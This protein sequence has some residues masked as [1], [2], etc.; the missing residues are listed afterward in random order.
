MRNAQIQG[1]DF[2]R[3]HDDMVEQHAS[4]HDQAALDA[5]RRLEYFPRA[6]IFAESRMREQMKSAWEQREQSRLR[7]GMN[8]R[9]ITAEASGAFFVFVYIYR[10]MYVYIYVCIYTYMHAGNGCESW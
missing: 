3:Q 4:K 8:R 2:Q 9:E 10:C 5:K 1:N 6:K 7:M